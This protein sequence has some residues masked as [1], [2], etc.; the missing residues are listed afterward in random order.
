MPQPLNLVLVAQLTYAEVV[1]MDRI[2]Q[3]RVLFSDFCLFSDN[4][5]FSLHSFCQEEIRCIGIMLIFPRRRIFY[6]TSCLY[7]LPLFQST[8]DSHECIY[9]SFYPI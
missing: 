8:H 4:S 5:N 2:I 9:G 3:S 7:R 6:K 1:L